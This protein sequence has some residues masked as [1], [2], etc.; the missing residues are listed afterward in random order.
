MVAASSC[1]RWAAA[2]NV[3]LPVLALSTVHKS[4]H[5][6]TR[7]RCAAPPPQDRTTQA[8]V[9]TYFRSRS[10]L[11]SP[12]WIGI[13]RGTSN[14]AYKF[15]DGTNVAQV[16]ADVAHASADAAGCGLHA[17]QPRPLHAQLPSNGVPYGHWSQGQWFS[18]GGG[19][20]FSDVSESYD[21]FTGAQQRLHPAHLLPLIDSQFWP[22][23]PS[24]LRSHR[25]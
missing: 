19:C 13:S 14:Q 20:T 1:T 23:H 6:I 12:A 8:F 2:S 10:S 22:A 18:G 24:G 7:T 15:I 17:Q 16:R 11:A 21:T 25:C 9:E 5:G 3:P 4:G